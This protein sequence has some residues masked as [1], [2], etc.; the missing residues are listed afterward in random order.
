MASTAK[1]AVSLPGGLLR[2]VEAERAR[3]GESRSAVV[4][5]ALGLLLSEKDRRR[6]L[7]AYVDG[8]RACPE[9]EDEVAAAAAAATRL[10][11]VEPW[12]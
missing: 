12:R 1:I 11:A 10:L 8:Y 7:R 2:E 5:R 4:Q 9:S 3:T 6:R